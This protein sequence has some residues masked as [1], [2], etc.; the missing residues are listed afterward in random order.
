MCARRASFT[1]PGRCGPVAAGGRRS[2]HCGNDRYGF[3]GARLF[4]RRGTCRD[5]SP[6]GRAGCRADF[7]DGPDPGAS[8]RSRSRECRRHRQREPHSLY[9]RVP[10]ILDLLG[11]PPMKPWYKVAVPD[12]ARVRRALIRLRDL[13]GTNLTARAKN[14]AYRIDNIRLRQF[15]DSETCGR[16]TR[17]RSALH[18]RSRA[19]LPRPACGE[20]VGVRGFPPRDRSIYPGAA[21]RLHRQ[22][23]QPAER[24]G[25]MERTA[26]RRSPHAEDLRGVRLYRHCVS[27]AGQVMAACKY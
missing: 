15:W 11:H 24:L 5:R 1:R 8:R 17:S 7:A 27:R 18:L 13:T 26:T 19:I 20:R 22:I 16:Q 21:G 6:S 12:T 25:A 23:P 2:S 3:R 4:R 9:S 14:R 10:P